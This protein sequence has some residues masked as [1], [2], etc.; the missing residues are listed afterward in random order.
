[1]IHHDYNDT[2]KSGWTEC[3]ENPAPLCLL[4][5]IQ[6]IQQNRGR[7]ELKEKSLAQIGSSRVSKTVSTVLVRM[8]CEF[9]PG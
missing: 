9:T 6:P 1:M 4:T 3:E 5:T 7:R 8:R 2:A